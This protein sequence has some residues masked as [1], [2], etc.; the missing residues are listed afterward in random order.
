MPIPT[1]LHRQALKLRGNRELSAPLR[2]E[3]FHWEDRGRQ[4]L[5]ALE[6][7]RGPALAR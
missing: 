6:E 3:A 1:R 2:R 4:L 5:E 7:L